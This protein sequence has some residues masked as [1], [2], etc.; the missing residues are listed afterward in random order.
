MILFFDTETTGLPDFRA[1]PGAEHQPHL[2]QL[3]ALLTEDDGTERASFS[4]IVKPPESGIP[5]GA[6]AVHGITT[7][8]AERCG[9]SNSRAVAL[10]DDL[11]SRADTLV[12]HNIRFDLSIM[13]T[14]W[15]RV[16]SARRPDMNAE[17]GARGRFCTMD[18]ASPI[19]NLPPTERMIA[20]GF[21]KPKPPKLEE[22]IRHFF[23]ED[24]IG[25]HDAL[26]DVRA[27][28]RVFFHLRSLE[29]VA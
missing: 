29:K 28:A 4:V 6:A 7:D 24:L 10:F 18:A 20:A 2:V 13:A 17:H 27:C 25:A 3:A 1:A 5:A 26:A 21:T 14:A 16:L 8:V 15:C 12:A 11:A 22:C 23:G 9:I 19:V